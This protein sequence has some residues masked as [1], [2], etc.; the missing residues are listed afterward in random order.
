[1]SKRSRAE[2]AHQLFPHIVEFARRKEVTGYVPLAQRISHPHFVMQSALGPIMF[3]CDERG[4]PALTSIVVNRFGVPGVGFE[5]RGKTLSELQGEVFAHDWGAVGVPT[6]RELQDADER[7]LNP[8]KAVSTAADD[9]DNTREDE[10]D[11]SNS[12]GAQHRRLIVDALNTG[13]RIRKLV[14]GNP[15]KRARRLRYQMLLDSEGKTVWQ[16]IA[17]NGPVATLIRAV[18]NRRVA[19]E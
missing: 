17:R 19:I 12:H 4:W 18:R 15:Y 5:D 10:V 1:M 8:S 2:L 14:E 9:E 16:F 6:V 3:L 7:G 13:K 11:V